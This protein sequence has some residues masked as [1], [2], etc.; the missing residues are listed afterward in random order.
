MRHAIAPLLLAAALLATGC[1][2]VFEIQSN[3]SW[4]GS[5]NDSDV[6]LH[7]AGDRTYEVTGGF[8]CVTMQKQTVDGYLRVR[9]RRAGSAFTETSAPYGTV[10]A[11]N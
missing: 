3:T 10:K 4:A 6:E 5:I 8:K 9:V 7:G 1:K 11:C 2:H